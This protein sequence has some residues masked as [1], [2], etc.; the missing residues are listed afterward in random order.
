[1]GVREAPG[2]GGSAPSFRKPQRIWDP[3]WLTSPGAVGAPEVH[4]EAVSKVSPPCDLTQW[5][6]R[7]NVSRWGRM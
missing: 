6:G 3:A 5:R 7:W 2:P 4:G 1:M